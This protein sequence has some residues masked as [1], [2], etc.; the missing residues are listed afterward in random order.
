MKRNPD[1]RSTW[2]HGF[3]LAESHFGP[4]VS[5]DLSSPCLLATLLGILAH[6]AFDHSPPPSP[7]R[8]LRLP[9]GRPTPRTCVLVWGFIFVGTHFLFAAGCLLSIQES[10]TPLQFPSC[11]VT[12]FSDTA[13]SMVQVWTETE[14]QGFPGGS[15]VK[16]PPANAGD[17]GSIPGPGGSH[18][19]QSNQAHT[20]QLLSLCSRAHAPQQEKPPTREA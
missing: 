15:V 17:M 18:M 6:S 9:L 7:H 16:N 2:A 12:S 5:Q 20:P 4:E 8:E 3:Y 1:P 13:S 19:P 14:I 11:L 10:G